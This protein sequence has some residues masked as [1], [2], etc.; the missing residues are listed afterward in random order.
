MTVVCVIVGV[1]SNSA[2]RRQRAV[3]HFLKH[4]ARFNY[5]YQ[6]RPAPLKQDPF[7]DPFGESSTTG[8][9]YVRTSLLGPA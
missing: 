3:E 9:R 8:V 4:C 2:N 1:Q 6:A 5:D 7:G